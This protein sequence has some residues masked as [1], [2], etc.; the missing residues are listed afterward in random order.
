MP[1]SRA[2]SAVAVR[3]V[4]DLEAVAAAWDALAARAPAQSPA[5]SRAFIASWVAAL[6]VAP[7]DQYYVV[8]ERNG[9]PVAL[10]PLLRRRAHGVRLLSFFA[11]PHVGCDVPLVDPAVLAELG[12]VGRAAL[13]SAMLAPL[14]D[15]DVVY[16]KSIPTLLHDGVDLFA[17]LGQSV[18]A[19]T[20]YRAEFES[21]DAADRLQRNKSRRKH[22]RQQGDRLAA[23]GEVGFEEQRNGPVAQAV[24]ETMFAQRASRFRDM[25]ID[26]PF[27]CPGI[28]P[29]YASLAAT[30]SGTDVV[31]HI[32]R[33]DGEIVAVRY[34]VVVGDR[35]FCLISSMSADPAIQSG[36]PGKQCLLRVMQ[37]VF[38]T[39]TRVFDMGAGL[40]D[41]KRHWCNVQVPVRHHYVPL[42]PV[43]DLAA[44]A[45]YL[46]QRL[47]QWLKASPRIMAAVRHVRG[48]LKRAM[49]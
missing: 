48:R 47:R 24:L 14:V 13:W 44:G 26:N 38:D 20:L 36:S 32:L 18:A 27:E 8:A 5:Q 2:S 49:P 46:W 21:F 35:M 10:L 3:L 41:E 19:E 33:L 15:V 30:G 6:G 43:G 40:T 45:H 29:F 22:D 7:T 25:G 28:R 9:F 1:A 4:H 12:S 11:G 37:T 23:M 34:N 17:E 39:G 42:S 16:L 31:L